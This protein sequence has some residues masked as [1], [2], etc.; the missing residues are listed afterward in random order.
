MRELRASMPLVIL[1]ADGHVIGADDPRLRIVSAPARLLEELARRERVRIA[2]ALK[3]P[4]APAR[5]RH[6]RSAFL[7]PPSSTRPAAPILNEAARRAY[8]VSTGRY[9]P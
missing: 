8:S 1:A 3:T 7:A 5:T 9:H 4:A 6:V 2:K